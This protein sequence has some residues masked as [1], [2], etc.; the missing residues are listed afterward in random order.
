M[1]D[2]HTWTKEFVHSNLDDGYFALCSVCGASGGPWEDASPHRTMTPF[3]A[4]TGL[5]LSYNCKVAKRQITTYQQHKKAHPYHP[6]TKT[7]GLLEVVERTAKGSRFPFGRDEYGLRNDLLLFF[8]HQEYLL[9][10]ESII[11]QLG[12]LEKASQLIKKKA[13]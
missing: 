7:D 4:G 6:R 11:E 8:E 2:T 5:W 10:C 3:L 9:K 1:K 12:G 13:P